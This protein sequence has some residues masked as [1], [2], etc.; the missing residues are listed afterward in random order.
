MSCK[1]NTQSNGPNKILFFLFAFSFVLIFGLQCNLDTSSYSSHMYVL[2][3][4]TVHSFMTNIVIHWLL[5]LMSVCGWGLG[6]CCSNGDTGLLT[7]K[8]FGCICS[9]LPAAC[10]I[11]EPE[12]SQGWHTPSSADSSGHTHKHT[13]LLWSSIKFLNTVLH[14]H[15]YIHVHR[16]RLN[17]TI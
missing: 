12:S 17:R 9:G 8:R 13:H 3:I 14:T 5:V 11:L 16:F 6:G 2:C 7:M 10:D 4:H 1:V 15:T